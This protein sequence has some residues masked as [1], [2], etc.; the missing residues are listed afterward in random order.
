M[1][2]AAQL[3]KIANTLNH[4]GTFE[5][6][7]KHLTEAAD[8]LEEALKALEHARLQI[9]CAASSAHLPQVLDRINAILTK[10]QGEKIDG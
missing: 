10:S 2:L 5:T 6:W 1:E 7:Q 9:T 3:R 4:S 8:L